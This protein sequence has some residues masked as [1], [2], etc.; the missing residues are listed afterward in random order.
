MSKQ[1]FIDSLVWLFGLKFSFSWEGTKSQLNR[2]TR[3]LM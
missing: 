3:R 1:M 2:H